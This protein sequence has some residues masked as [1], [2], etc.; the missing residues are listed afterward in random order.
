MELEEISSSGLSCSFFNFKLAT[1]KG[2]HHPQSVIAPWVSNE[3]FLITQT[4]GIEWCS[5]TLIM[6]KDLEANGCG[7]MPASIHCQ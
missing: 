4:M 7:F 3:A 5:K 6:G 2:P 1:V